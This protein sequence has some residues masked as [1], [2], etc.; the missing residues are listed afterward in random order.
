[1]R[2]SKST[3]PPRTSRR[4]PR[5][6]ATEPSSR[7]ENTRTHSANT[8][9]AWSTSSRLYLPSVAR[10]IQDSQRIADVYFSARTTLQISGFKHLTRDTAQKLAQAMTLAKFPIRI[11]LQLARDEEADVFMEGLKL[12]KV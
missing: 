4:I 2:Q 12:E 3:S 8:Q 6:D 10:I 1:M 7:R 9:R 5:D 11:E